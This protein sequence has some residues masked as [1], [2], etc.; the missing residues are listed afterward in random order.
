M[1]IEDLGDPKA[2]NSSIQFNP[3][4]LVNS[5][6]ILVVECHTLIVLY[7]KW[8]SHL[9]NETMAFALL[10]PTKNTN[11]QHVVCMDVGNDWQN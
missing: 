5:D 8:P 3:G 4:G 7:R 6:G 11:V 2:T 10:R 9:Q 1:N